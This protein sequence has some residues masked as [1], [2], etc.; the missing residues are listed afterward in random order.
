MKKNTYIK[1][2]FVSHHHNLLLEDFE[3]FQQPNLMVKILEVGPNYFSVC[4][5]KDDSELDIQAFLNKVYY[6]FSSLLLAFNVGTMGHFS[7][8]FKLV[9]PI[10]LSVVENGQ[11]INVSPINFPYKNDEPMLTLNKTL[12]WQ[13]FQLFIS[14]LKEKN[15]IFKIEYLKGLYNLHNNFLDINFVNEAFS[16]FYRSFEFF[17]T[18]KI[19]SVNKLSNEKK[20]LRGVLQEFGFEEE[21]LKDFDKIYNLRCNKAMHAQKGITNIEIEAAIR[22]KVFLDAL[23]HKHYKHLWKKNEN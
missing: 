11:E 22:L 20:Q 19:L 18:Q 1:C 8:D 5:F 7:F 4:C 3:Y 12:V 21:I 16:N 9:P 6:I 13:V 14:F 15:E 17:C 23:M 2:K 10:N